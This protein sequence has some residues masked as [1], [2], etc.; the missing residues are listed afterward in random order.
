M[1]AGEMMNR[2]RELLR[3][4][5]EPVEDVEVELTRP[6]PHCGEQISRGATVCIHCEREITPLLSY[7]EFARR[8]GSPH[9]GGPPHHRPKE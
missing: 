5:S 6:C 1:R 4:Q 8:F 7:G 9:S 3:R 2:L